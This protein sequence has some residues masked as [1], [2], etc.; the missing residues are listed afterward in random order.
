[1]D[2]VVTDTDVAPVLQR[3][4]APAPVH[5]HVTGARVW[6]TYVT[7]VS[8]PSGPR[9][10]VGDRPDVLDSRGGWRRDR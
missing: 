8:S 6:L 2:D 10:A 7:E 3:D 9:F 4:R 5:R 1:M